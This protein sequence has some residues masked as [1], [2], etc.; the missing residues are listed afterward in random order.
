MKIRL[1]VNGVQQVLTRICY[2]LRDP[3]HPEAWKGN[4]RHC[5][6]HITQYLAGRHT[7]GETIVLL[8]TKG[9]V[10]HSIVVDV[11][12]NVVADSYSL[13]GK[14]NR[15]SYNHRTG[16]YRFTVYEREHTYQR[17]FMLTRTELDDY[18][19]TT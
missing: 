17:L 19:R 15:L 7:S 10:A 18:C 14:F 9:T 5:H 13:P 2:T 12:G 4:P 11:R 3:K 8:G 6:T 1:N 16:E